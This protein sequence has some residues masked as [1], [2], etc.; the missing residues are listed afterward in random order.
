MI[1]FLTIIGARPQIIKAVERRGDLETW[2]KG[3][4][5]TK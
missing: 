5:G 3:D 4:D 1:K 2:R